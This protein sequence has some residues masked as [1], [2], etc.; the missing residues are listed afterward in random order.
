MYRGATHS[1]AH[2]IYTD[3]AKDKKHVPNKISVEEPPE[4]PNINIMLD[5]YRKLGLGR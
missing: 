5:K 1:I 3:P 4:G 2:A